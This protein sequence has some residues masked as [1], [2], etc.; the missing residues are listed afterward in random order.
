MS[1]GITAPPEIAIIISPEISFVLA[2]YFSTVIENTSG[3]IFAIANPIRKTSAHAITGEDISNTATRHIIPRIEVHI[4]N[5]RE[6]ILV[7]IIAPANVPSIRPKKYTL[8]PDSAVV[9]S[10]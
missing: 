9:E 4:K 10:I 8:L 2:G 1:K 5:F 3:K 6:E 7:S